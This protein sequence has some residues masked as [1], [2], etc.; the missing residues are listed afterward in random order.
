[1][2]RIN[3]KYFLGFTLLLVSCSGNSSSVEE[4]GESS[5]VLSIAESTTP[6]QATVN[7]QYKVGD[8]GPG[9]GIIFYAD[10]AGF[11]NSDGGD[12]SIG[13]MCTTGTCNYLE[14]V[15]GDG[16]SGTIEEMPEFVEY[17]NSNAGNIWLIPS[18]DA[19]NEMCKFAFSD[20][21]YSI[22]NDNGAFGELTAT[23]FPYEDFGGTPFR[24]FYY[25]SSSKVGEETVA[26]SFGTGY[27]TVLPKKWSAH[28]RL[29][30][31]FAE[32]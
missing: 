24:S 26:Q 30:R 16:L 10:A 17:F 19:L 28:L 6:T 14:M 15:P 9:G 18:R 2:L 31:A 22:C 21:K 12:T 8:P 3:P 27:Q 7:L 20:T 11:D 29:V 1:M 4:T 32:K 13:A 25:W 23:S 5:P